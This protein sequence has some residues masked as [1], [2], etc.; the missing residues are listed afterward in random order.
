MLKAYV[1]TLLHSVFTNCAFRSLISV[2]SYVLA[3]NF[4]LEEL[5]KTASTFQCLV[6]SYWFQVFMHK[7][8]NGLTHSVAIS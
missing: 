6:C 3:S 5:T 7:F 8:R 2:E 1:Q 4:N